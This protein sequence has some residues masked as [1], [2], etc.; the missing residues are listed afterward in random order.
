MSSAIHRVAERPSSKLSR[1]TVEGFD[2]FEQ[3]SQT[4]FVHEEHR[5]MAQKRP[6]ERKSNELFYV[7][8]DGKKQDAALHEGIL[9]GGDEAAA[10]EIGKEAARRAGL[11]EEQIVKLYSEK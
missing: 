3:P 1:D 9:S 6:P 4:F 8:K 11:T 5:Q 10:R 7:D 2:K